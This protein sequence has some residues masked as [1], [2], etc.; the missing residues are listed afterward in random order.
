MHVVTVSVAPD[1]RRIPD[2]FLHRRVSRVRR[3]LEQRHGLRPAQ[4]PAP[5]QSGPA[6]QPTDEARHQPVAVAGLDGEATE[7]LRLL[8]LVERYFR[9]LPAEPDRKGGGGARACTD[10]LVLRHG[11][12]P[13][14]A[15][16]AVALF[17]ASRTAPPGASPT[18]EETT[19]PAPA[20]K[21]GLSVRRRPH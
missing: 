16:R 18:V 8:R 13:P 1:G 6:A 4:G 19:A 21:R 2:A 12:P 5:E 3:R 15:R 17:L 14:A 7:S 9:A 10:D 20:P 11:V